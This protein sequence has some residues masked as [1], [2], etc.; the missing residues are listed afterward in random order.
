M[1][2]RAE[3]AL[4]GGRRCV[5]GTLHPLEGCR[6]H[7]PFSRGCPSVSYCRALLLAELAHLQPAVQP[8]QPPRPG[9]PVLGVSPPA[10]PR[11]QDGELGLGMAIHRQHVGKGHRA[12][13]VEQRELKVT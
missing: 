10:C 12:D 7:P 4:A 3:T 9:W 8:P 11:Q 13:R 1:G 6:P 2:F 5:L